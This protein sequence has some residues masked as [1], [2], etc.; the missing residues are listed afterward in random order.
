MPKGS[1]LRQLKAR[2]SS[3]GIKDKRQNSASSRKRKSS[4][5]S[6]GAV[7]KAAEEARRGALAR[8]RT[9]STFNPFE[10]RITKPKH[11]VLGRKVKGVTGKP[12]VS[13]ATALDQ[14]RRTLLPEIQGRHRSGAFLDRRFGE[15]DA[16]LTPEERALERFTRERQNR[17]RSGD[18]GGKRSLFNLD[19]GPEDGLTHYGQSLNVDEMEDDGLG[20]GGFDDDDEHGGIDRATTSKLNF[21]GFDEENDDDVSRALW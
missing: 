10:E 2:L 1:Q 11:D 8:I 16:N 13:R 18:L 7:Q 15:G 9:D 4:S 19:D 5:T 6:A 14:R 21:G 17:A 3:D 12:G 20:L